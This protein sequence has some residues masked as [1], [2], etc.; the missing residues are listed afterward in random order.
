MTLVIDASVFNKLFLKEDD[1]P[2]AQAFLTAAITARAPL[3][4]PTLLRLEMCKVALHYGVAFSVPLG[5]LNVHIAA[6]LELID[7][8]DV[9]WEQAE[10]LSHHGHDKS[11]YPSLEDSL[12]HA[13]AIRAGGTFVTA[14]TRHLAKTVADFGHAVALRDWET[15]R[16]ERS[17]GPGVK[18][19]GSD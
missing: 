3:I 8:S 10:T 14:D 18:S 19:Q 1:T 2:D 4:A 9:I 13:L 17:G 5:I 7:P 15:L 11:G 12:Y 16:F 6:G